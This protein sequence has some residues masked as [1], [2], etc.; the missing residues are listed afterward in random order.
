MIM[1]ALP[2]VTWEYLLKSHTPGLVKDLFKERRLAS[3]LST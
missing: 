1:R 3:R 2:D